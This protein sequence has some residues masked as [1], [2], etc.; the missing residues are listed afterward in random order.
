MEKGKTMNEQ[1]AIDWYEQFRD[2]IIMVGVK[3]EKYTLA[4]KAMQTAITALLKQIPKRVVF[5]Y[6]HEFAANCPACNVKIDSHASKKYCC[7]CGQRLAW[8]D[9]LD[10]SDDNELP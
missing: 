8:G 3:K 4:L 9:D 10:W 2:N 5:Y 6:T 1:E 7:W